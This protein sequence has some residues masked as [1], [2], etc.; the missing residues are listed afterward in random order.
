MTLN[1]FIIHLRQFHLNDTF[2]LEKNESDMHYNLSLQYVDYLVPVCTLNYH[3]YAQIK[4]AKVIVS[5]NAA[6]V[7]T[8]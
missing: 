2:Y 5:S 8:L 7:K 1:L 6:V 3:A 4:Y